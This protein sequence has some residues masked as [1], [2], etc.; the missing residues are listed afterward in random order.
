MTKARQ[1][2]ELREAYLILANNGV[3]PLG[4]VLTKLQQII[5]LV[6]PYSVPGEE[7]DQG[8]VMFDDDSMLLWD[9]D[10]GDLRE[11]DDTGRG[12]AFSYPHNVYDP[13]LH[14]QVCLVIETMR[15]APSF[16][17][18]NEAM[19]VRDYSKAYQIYLDAEK[20]KKELEK[21]LPTEKDKMKKFTVYFTGKLP[22]Y[23]CEAESEDAAASMAEGLLDDAPEWVEIGD[24]EEGWVR[25][26]EKE[27][28]N[29]AK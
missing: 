14:A 23:E 16:D 2:A 15:H 10:N 24:I 9:W 12:K 17:E 19:N 28:A 18:F 4:T 27:D 11:Y 1:W 3:E 21:P 8:F 29:N 6:N 7:G 20:A 25:E 22:P 26:N 5:D 13:L